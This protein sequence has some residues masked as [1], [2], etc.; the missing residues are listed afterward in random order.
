MARP[1]LP[2]RDLSIKHKLTLVILLTSG[3]ALLMASLGFALY[4][5]FAFRQEKVRELG[6]FAEIIAA[7]S[8]ATLSRDQG[9]AAGEILA[10]LPSDRNVLLACLYSRDG[11]L[12]SGYLNSTDPGDSCPKAAPSQGHRFENKRLMLAQPVV[13][14]GQSVGTVYLVSGLEEIGQRFA[15]YSMISGLVLL[16]S[17]LVA[18]IFS[19]R[20]R[21][22]ISDPILKLAGAAQSI[23]ENQ[24]YTLRVESPG[25]D[26]VGKLTHAFNRMLSEIQA[27][28]DELRSARDDLE[29]RVEERTTQL[30]AE[31]TSRHEAEKALKVSEE[32]LR[33]SQK[34]EAIG[35]L[36][37]GVAHDF[38]NLLT[39]IMGYTD[40]LTN[41][42]KDSDPMKAQVTE[43]RKAS[44][45]A[46][47]LTRQLLAFSRKQILDPKVMNLNWSVT[48]L[49]VMMRRLI[50]E[51]IELVTTLAE[52]LGRIKADPGQIEQVILNLAV[53]AR[54]AMPQGGRLLIETANL[55]VAAGAEGGDAAV[56]A[57]S[58]VVLQV[59]DT[60]V[61]MDEETMSRIFE[62]FFT[63][64][65]KSRGTG[66]GLSTVYGIV[67][68]SGGHIRVHSEP[69]RG[70]SFR[71]LL[72][73]TAGAVEAEEPAPA[74]AFADRGSET[75]LLVEDDELVRDLTR[76]ILLMHGYKVLEAP[77]GG[78]ALLLCESHKGPIDLMLTDV[79]M[80]NLSGPDLVARVSPLRPEMKIVFMSG[81]TDVGDPRQGKIGAATAFIQKPFTP[82]ELT[83]KLREVLGPAP[84]A[85]VLEPG[86]APQG[87]IE[88]APAEPELAF[89]L[90]PLE[91]L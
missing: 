68:Q 72:P 7:S 86:P 47:D 55:E 78:E 24:D 62:P 1:G 38:N 43:I 21:T 18:F 29:R 23:S 45:R 3:A 22:R 36:A 67:T 40:M 31:T 16:G 4:D 20:L 73:M 39:A 44:H 34:M 26:E 56:T 87:P 83:R 51:D 2:A 28:D 52:G 9:E 63:T 35:R 91:G 66:L 82:A 32:A 30:L 48:N 10:S 41:S 19:S 80:P 12:V 37:G 13:F 88:E 33:H 6:S 79:V 15:R 57:G 58:Y 74:E 17:I 50:G 76:G 70:T 77:Q 89:T 14:A 61:G 85:S 11:K 54:D 71:I 49:E 90:D 65:D 5:L 25:G 69:G 64:K 8:S 81:Y 59:T 27:R 60:G 42:L 84:R 53:N 46:A 75:I